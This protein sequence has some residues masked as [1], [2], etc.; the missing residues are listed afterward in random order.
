MGILSAVASQVV[1]CSDR[2]RERPGYLY[3]SRLCI[4]PD[5]TS[6]QTDSQPIGADRSSAS[7]H[8][9]SIG[10]AMTESSLIAGY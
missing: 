3:G 2:G 7:R 9:W 10:Q 8:P 6:D 1:L 4:G 5:R